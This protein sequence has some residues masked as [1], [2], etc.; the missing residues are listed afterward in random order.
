M[1]KYEYIIC[2]YTILV[3]KDAVTVPYARVLPYQRMLFYLLSRRSKRTKKWYKTVQQ[4]NAFKP[5]N[6]ICISN[7]EGGRGLIDSSDIRHDGPRIRRVTNTILR[8]ENLGW[9][10]PVQSIHLGHHQFPPKFSLAQ[11]PRGP[12]VNGRRCSFNLGVP[13]IGAALHLA[14]PLDVVGSIQVQV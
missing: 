10:R 6:D 2:V 7:D 9:P 5:C 13:L 8:Q 11:R 4:D 14:C 1:D 3:I 12:V